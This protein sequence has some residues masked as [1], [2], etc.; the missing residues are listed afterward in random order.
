M[1]AGALLVLVAAGVGLAIGLSGGGSTPSTGARTIAAPALGPIGPEGVPVEQGSPL[2]APGAPA[3]GASVDG[4]PCGTSEQ[5]AFHIHARLTIFVD[6]RQRSVPA[7]VG[8]GD[9]QAQQTG[10]GVLVAGGSCIAWLHTHA[11]D[12]I[13]HV[14]SPV[15]RGFTLGNFFDVW[16]QPLSAGQVGPATGAVTVWVD[17]KLWK[18]DVRSIPLKPHTQIQLDV[19]APVVRP[20]LISSWPGL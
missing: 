7:G 2:A 16:G 9:P 17:G 12:G 19:G 18:G 14:E 10:K 5:L 1:L 20:E 3:P 15:V 8:I 11:A 13:V 4:I 6:G